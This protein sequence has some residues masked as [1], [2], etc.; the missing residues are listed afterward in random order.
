MASSEDGAAWFTVT[1]PPWLAFTVSLKFWPGQPA[2]T[3]MG[4]ASTTTVSV[5]NKAGMNRG[6]MFL[7]GL[8]PISIY[9]GRVVVNYLSQTG[10]STRALYHQSP[11]PQRNAHTSHSA[12]PGT[13]CYNRCWHYHSEG[14]LSLFSSTFPCQVVSSRHRAS[15]GVQAW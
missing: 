5:S 3:G 8:F 10:V 15:R 13:A 4:V 14:R 7:A 9:P 11:L 12:R 2:S 1:E 6:K